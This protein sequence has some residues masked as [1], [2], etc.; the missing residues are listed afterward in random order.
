M[1][2]TMTDEA[3]GPEVAPGGDESPARSR[4]SGFDV[5]RWIRRG[6]WLLV[7]AALLALVYLL[8]SAF[9]PRWWAQQVGDQVQG[10]VTAG[11]LWG[12]FYGFVF[13]LFPLLVL[14]Q[15]RRRFLSWKGRAAVAL[16]AVVLAVPNW[17]TLSIVVGNSRAAHA[18][19][20]ILDVE[21]PGFRTATLIGV[22]IGLALAVAITG[23]FVMLRRRKLEVR[24][25]KADRDSHNP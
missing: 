14:F 8:S 25:L 19:E 22:L 15:V 23:L 1:I 11:T 7:V 3:R 4:G 9:F 18:G 10:R 5:D 24:R 20:R 17:L 6:V 2:R 16:L 13:S 21:G 12:L